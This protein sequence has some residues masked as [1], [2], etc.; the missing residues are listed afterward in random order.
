MPKGLKPSGCSPLA[1]EDFRMKK[2]LVTG[3][4]GPAGQNVAK[5]LLKRGY[6]VLGTD[7]RSLSIPES[8]FFQVPEA[9]SPDFLP[10]L[11]GIAERQEVALVIPTVSEELPVLA[12]R[13]Q[14]PVP[15]LISDR[16]SVLLAND[17][18]L[19]C[20][21]LQEKGVSVPK[22]LL[23][24]QV[25][26]SGELEEK[27]GWPCLSKPRVSRGGREVRLYCPEDF[28]KILALNDNY[29]LQ[30]FIPGR[31]YAPNVYLGLN[32]TI[33]VVIEKTKLEHGIVG[34]AKE[35]VV[36]ERE[37]VAELAVKAGRALKLTGP[38]DLDLRQRLD[39][40]F[41]VLE[42]NARF[43]AN[44]ALAP[45]ILERALAGALP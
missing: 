29:L 5:L 10:A 34:N 45:E 38:L 13:W 41:A 18:Y 4:G 12:G 30:E 11:R 33:A 43:G 32:E 16:K 35:A 37:D 36:V 40:S 3:I 27:L 21:A 24:S 23:P 28:A 39:G 22:F 19:T 6:Q 44:I 26:S 9:T 25:E 7:L 8:E 20:K 14:S 1:G 15:L 17:K 31:E 2:I 42:I